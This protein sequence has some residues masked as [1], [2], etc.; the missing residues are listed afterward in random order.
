MPASFFYQ[1]NDRGVPRELWIPDDRIEDIFSPRNFSSDFASLRDRSIAYTGER[2]SAV[3]TTRG[4]SLDP[5]VFPEYL[6]NQDG[7]TF[8]TQKAE[9]F[10][11]EYT[12]IS[13]TWGRWMLKSREADTPVNGGYWN[14]PANELFTRAELDNAVKNVSR[15]GSNVWMDVLC[16]PQDDGDPKKAREIAKQ[17][18]IFKLA[19][20]AIVWLCSGGDEW[21]RELCSAVPEQKLMVMPTIM[22]LHNLPEFNRLL[23]LVIDIPK[24]IPWTSSLWT[25]QETALRMDAVFYDRA[26]F[27][28]IHQKTG[29]EIT[30]RHF[31]RTLQF[32][33]E[34]ILSR[35]H[36]ILE[37]LSNPELSFWGIQVLQDNPLLLDS[38]SK[39][40]PM[41]NSA[42]EV[43]RRTGLLDLL[44][45]NAAELLRASSQRV[46][47]RPHD[48][49]YGIMG[50]IGVAISVNYAEDPS[51]VMTKFLVELHRQVPAEMQTFYRQTGIDSG[52][53]LW[54]VD[55]TCQIYGLIRQLSP[56]DPGFATGMT[57]QGQLE[58]ANLLHLSEAG[59]EELITLSLAGRIVSSLDG[60][61][62][63][64]LMGISHNRPLEK[65]V[66]D[67]ELMSAQFCSLILHLS[68]RVK[69]GLLFLGSIRSAKGLAWNFVYLIVGSSSV[70][71]PTDITDSPQVFLRFGILFTK[72]KLQYSR[73]IQG[74]FLLR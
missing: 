53:K 8:S 56:P 7:I 40:V 6:V 15:G 20:R 18:S 10:S 28:L 4:V 41:T 12:V 62:L 50:A 61:A 54:L 59:R 1:Q 65:V 58:V 71:T 37:A 2:A 73:P 49:V 52:G 11:S 13:Y 66:L 60:P 72:N 63:S 69:L 24:I 48:R 45:T 21:I 36:N 17:S 64:E 55:T 29:N 23:G 67:H 16:I 22:D 57:A 68:A 35:K 33:E 44:T 39:L 70:Q 47:Q 32:L 14:V 27:P 74:M 19:S 43:L 34:Q 9:S 38:L 51:V 3:E 30:A 25:L 46:C 5:A 26:G 31:I 42:V